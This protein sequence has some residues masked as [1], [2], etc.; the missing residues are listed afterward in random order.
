MKKSF[1]MRITPYLFLLPN[2][3]IYLLFF[4]IPVII[5]FQYAFTDY[6]GLVTM[7]FVGFDNFVKL[8]KD[9]LFWTVIKNTFFYVICT[10]PLLF[11]VSLMM[12]VLLI[13]KFLP[14][15]GLF[16][17]GYYWP[18]MISGII[19]GL[20]WKWILGNNF[21]V[22]NYFLERLH[23]QPVAWLTSSLPSKIA[24]VM[25]TIWSRAGFFMVIFMGGL[26]SIP[27]VY[28]EA[29]KIDGA[30][31][32]KI[33]FNITLPLLKPTIFLVLML[34]AID[35]F[36]EYPL[37]LSLTGGGPGTSTTLMIQ[38]IYQQGFEKLNVGYASAASIFMFIIL[39]IFTSIQFKVSKGGAVE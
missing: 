37:I 28:Y 30:G 13:Q 36:K 15:K 19:V 32:I 20:M 3:I 4:I 1:G 26:E 24:I 2:F 22:L 34:G 8:L 16:R 33:F 7:N 17:A 39:F 12:A 11:V 38:Y 21:G 31:R 14:F 18:V 6:D 10:V 5:A 35:A 9:P 29:A 25:A 23:M 27:E